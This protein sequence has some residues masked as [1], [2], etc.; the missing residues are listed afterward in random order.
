VGR[1]ETGLAANPLNKSKLNE[2]R[3]QAQFIF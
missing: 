1:I 2:V 3:L